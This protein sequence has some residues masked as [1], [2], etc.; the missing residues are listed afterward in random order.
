MLINLKG[1]STKLRQLSVCSVKFES[2]PLRTNNTEKTNDFIS[3]FCMWFLTQLYESAETIKPPLH[4]QKNSRSINCYFEILNTEIVR[5][6]TF[7]KGYYKIVFSLLI[8]QKIQV[9]MSQNDQ[10]TIKQLF[11]VWIEVKRFEGEF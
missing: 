6:I 9:A 11:H 1:R 8:L 2:V 7:L 4:Y 3:T 5:Q 10:I